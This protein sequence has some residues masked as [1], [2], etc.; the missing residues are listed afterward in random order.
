MEIVFLGT[1]SD[2]A[3]P[4]REPVC[5]LIKGG[6]NLLL[7]CSPSVLKQLA[8]VGMDPLDIDAVFI[9][10]RHAGH[11]LGLPFLT[12][13]N[14]VRGRKRELLVFLPE[15]SVLER[16]H[17]LSIEGLYPGECYHR[18]LFDVRLHKLKTS[19][20]DKVSLKELMRGRQESSANITVRSAPLSHWE[21]ENDATKFFTLGYSLEFTDV[22]LK[23]AYAVDTR[24][25]ENTVKL[26]R[27][28][29]ILIH[30]ASF[31]HKA[32]KWALQARHSTAREAAEVAKRANAK[33]LV[34][35]HLHPTRFGRKDIGNVFSED[36]K[37]VFDGELVMPNDLD[38]L[39]PWSYLLSRPRHTI[40]EE[41]QGKL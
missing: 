16:L 25:C 7:D 2:Y 34:L 31:E 21:G 12:W 19:D 13:G 20:F 23:I 38:V 3:T 4:E 29:D 33:V 36:A 17:E 6:A 8:L 30:D 18:K 41:Y 15:D 35:V 26:A 9:S 27:N 5:V 22:D 37:H 39:D 28:A 24:P 1:G 10:H 11:S 14:I 40:K 32:A